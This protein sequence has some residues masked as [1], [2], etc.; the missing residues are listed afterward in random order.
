V[1]Q[2]TL[3]RSY[4]VSQEKSQVPR[5]VN[6]GT[7]SNEV[8]RFIGNSKLQKKET[9]HASTAS[10]MS[11]RLVVSNNTGLDV[12]SRCAWSWLV[13]ITLTSATR[14]CLF[15]WTEVICH[16][17]KTVLA[18]TCIAVSEL[19][20]CFWEILDTKSAPSRYFFII[21]RHIRANL[22]AVYVLRW[23][24]NVLRVFNSQTYRRLADKSHLR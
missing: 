8:P 15:D 7:G 23:R 1:Q 17:A 12:T 24:W 20:Y 10:I 14:G 22:E 18:T 16:S 4:P 11:P 3:S 21:S 6:L 13:A 2:E 5:K 9:H 19:V